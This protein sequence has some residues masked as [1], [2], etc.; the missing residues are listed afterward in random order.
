[1]AAADPYGD[2]G[3]EDRQW[4]EPERAVYDASEADEDGDGGEEARDGLRGTRSGVGRRAHV[5]IGVRRVRA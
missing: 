2:E 3:E 1:M 4:N 5:R